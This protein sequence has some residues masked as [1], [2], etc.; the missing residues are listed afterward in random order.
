[1]VSAEDEELSKTKIIWQDLSFHSRFCLDESKA[2]PEM[3]CFFLCSGDLWLLAVLN[4]PLVWAYL[5][6]NTIHGKTETLR[7]KAIYMD[8]VPVPTPT[9]EQRQ[10]TEEKVQRLIE[11]SG[12]VRR[13]RNEILDWLRTE[14]SISRPSKNLKSLA[15]LNSDEFVAEIRRLRGTNKPLSVAALRDLREDYSLFLKTIQGLLSEARSLECQISDMVNQAYGLAPEEI[16][17]MWRTAPPRMPV[18]PRT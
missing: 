16:D 6:R 14:H 3:T 17:L 11:I 18:G 10:L 7:L 12:S 8:A 1:M 13:T 4:S 5:W 9:R 2:I 15:T